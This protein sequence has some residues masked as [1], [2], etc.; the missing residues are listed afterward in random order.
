MGLLMRLLNPDM[1]AGGRK[2]RAAIIGGSILVEDVRDNTRALQQI[3]YELR[4]GQIGGDVNAFHKCIIACAIRV[5]KASVETRQ[6]EKRRLDYSRRRFCSLPFQEAG[7][8]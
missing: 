5:C 4:I 8:Y 3:A 1:R 7:S 2:C 6:N